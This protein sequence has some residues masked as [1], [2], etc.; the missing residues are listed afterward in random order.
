MGAKR[1][2]KCGKTI[3]EGTEFCLGC[4][5]PL[6]ITDRTT[7]KAEKVAFSQDK[8]RRSFVPQVSAAFQPD[9]FV[10]AETYGPDEYY[11]VTSQRFLKCSINQ[12]PVGGTD[13]RSRLGGVSKAIFLD[14]IALI[15]GFSSI[16][17]KDR[18]HSRGP[19]LRA[20]G[21]ETFDGD[22][23]CCVVAR[24]H[25][26]FF[27]RDPIFF[28]DRLERAYQNV[29]EGKRSIDEWLYRIGRSLP[30]RDG[31]MIA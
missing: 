22:E 6:A 30:G 17:Y 18:E 16:W 12:E 2:A 9:E 3:F 27:H 10:F 14:R 4:G 24:A 7:R 11:I 1:C 26:G 5:T 21:L 15:R 31:N 29:E 8:Y 19:M 25:P 13:Q 20:F 23:R 28:F